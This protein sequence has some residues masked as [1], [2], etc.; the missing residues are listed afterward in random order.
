MLAHVRRSH[1]ICSRHASPIV[2]ARHRGS[3]MTATH[4]CRATNGCSPTSRGWHRRADAAFEQLKRQDTEAIWDAAVRLE[5][6]RR[7]RIFSRRSQCGSALRSRPVTRI[8]AEARSLVPERIGAQVPHRAARRVRHDARHRDGRSHDL[9]C[10]RTLAFA[11]RHRSRP[12]VARRSPRATPSRITKAYRPTGRRDRARRMRNLEAI[13]RRSRRP[14]RRSH[15]R[16]AITSVRATSTSSPKR[17][18]SPCAIA[19]TASCV[20]R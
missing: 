17:T 6:D 4:S 19:S 13:T 11:L 20:T 15:R 14:A 12:D 7:R 3:K 1:R 16:R 2:P 10:E 9:D 8:V 5:L 18:V